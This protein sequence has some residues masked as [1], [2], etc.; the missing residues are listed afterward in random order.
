MRN[1]GN[2]PETPRLAAAAEGLQGGGMINP[3]QYGGVVGKES[4]CNRRKELKALVRAMENGE[5]F[6]VYSER[7]MGKTSL[8]RLALDHLPKRRFVC[9]YVDLWPTDGD[10]SFAASTAKALAERLGGTAGKLLQAAKTWFGR[11]SPTITTDEEGRPKVVFTIHR[12]RDAEPELEEVLSAPERIAERR[13]CRVVVV[14]DEFQQVLEYPNSRVER[15]LRSVIQSQKGVSYVFLGSR[16]HLIQKMFLDQSRPLY[17][18]GGHYELGPIAAPE[19]TPFIRRRFLASKRGIS[20]AMIQ[21]LCRLTGGHPFYTQHLCHALWEISEMGKAVKPESLETALSL[22]LERESYAYS[23]L[24]DSL[25]LNQQRFLR[26]IALEPEDVKV[27][28]SEFLQRYGLRTASNAQRVVP[29]LLERDL[30]DR[31]RGSFMITDRFFR[32]WVQRMHAAAGE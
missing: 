12:G 15:K 9:A 28:A 31:S 21:E 4:F 5:R 29:A 6:F 3:F 20:D 14:F 7:R 32:I 1:I 13:K 27:F 10:A 30:I 16:K 24:W 17:R 26:G 23:A 22:L 11:L 25:A 19:W 8:V 18:A 2:A